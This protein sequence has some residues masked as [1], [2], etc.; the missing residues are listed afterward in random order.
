MHHFY[1]TKHIQAK[2]H[3]DNEGNEQGY[4]VYYPDGYVSWSPA[5][6]F[7]ASYRETGYLT[8]GHALHAAKYEGKKVYRDG[9]NGKGMFVVYQKAYPDGISINKNTQEALGLPEGTICKF[10]PYLLMKTAD[11]SFV[12]WLASQTDLLAEDWCIA[13]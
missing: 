9:W 4:K 11:G 8:F 12:P 13:D 1:G 2:P 7:E 3:Y 6:A 5:K 10:L